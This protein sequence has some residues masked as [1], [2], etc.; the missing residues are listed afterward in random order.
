[1]QPHCQHV[2]RRGS[3]GLPRTLQGAER[4]SESG[5]SPRTRAAP[6]GPSK[7]AR[8][9]PRASAWCV[10]LSSRTPQIQRPRNLQGIMGQA[11]RAQGVL[12]YGMGRTEVGVGGRRAQSFPST[13]V[14][15]PS[16]TRSDWSLRK[17]RQHQL[18]AA[19][20]PNQTGTREAATPTS[21]PLGTGLPTLSAVARAGRPPGSPHYTHHPDLHYP[22]EEQVA[23]RGESSVQRGPCWAQGKPWRA[24]DR[25]ADLWRC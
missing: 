12:K 9:E 5:A 7:A 16:P 23:W 2:P 11:A 10:V 19:P 21:G 8:A 15:T 1:M 24:C 6:A 3:P 13:R 17:P 4:P 14:S 20:K 18:T 22:G 25:L